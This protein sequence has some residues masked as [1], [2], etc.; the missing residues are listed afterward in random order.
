MKNILDKKTIEDL[1]ALHLACDSDEG[2]V[3]TSL[4]SNENIYK[5]LEVLLDNGYKI[6]RVK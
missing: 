6:E 3:I 4:T 1:L 2:K 5:I